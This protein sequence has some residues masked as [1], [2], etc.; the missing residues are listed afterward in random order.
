MSAIKEYLHQHAHLCPRCE[1]T[2][3]F[4]NGT[5]EYHRITLRPAA[6]DGVAAMT[7][8]GTTIC[9]ACK[10]DQENRYI[11]GHALEREGSWPI[12]PNGTS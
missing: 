2:F 12:K 11:P 4:N 6:E 8:V 5:S 3:V 1:Q 10:Y 7:E 9:I